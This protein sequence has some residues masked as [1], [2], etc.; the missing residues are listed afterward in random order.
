MNRFNND[1]IKAN[2]MFFKFTEKQL[3]QWGAAYDELFLGKRIYN[4]WID[5]KAINSEK[6]FGDKE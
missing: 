3:E 5:D 2:M 6:F 1:S 4:F